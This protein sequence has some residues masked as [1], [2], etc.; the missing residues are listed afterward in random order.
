MGHL[1]NSWQGSQLYCTWSG[2]KWQWWVVRLHAEC[3]NP[4]MSA[5]NALWH[6]SGCTGT[7]GH[8]EDQQKKKKLVCGGKRILHCLLST[9]QKQIHAVH[10]SSFM[11]TSTRLLFMSACSHI[12]RFKCIYMCVCLCVCV[13][14]C[15]AF[16]Y[17]CMCLCCVYT[18]LSLPLISV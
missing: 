3:W 1:C 13:C 18:C 7:S 14:V 11:K 4:Q 16:T 6:V 9:H 10:F 17:M 2:Y 8:S 12:R 5:C 15:V